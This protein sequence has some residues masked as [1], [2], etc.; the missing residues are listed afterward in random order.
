MT[1]RSD[2]IYFE[3]LGVITHEFT[4]VGYG[5]D[6]PAPPMTAERLLV[7]MKYRQKVYGKPL[8]DGFV[9]PPGIDVAELLKQLP[10][11]PQR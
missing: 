8:P 3:S 6:N 7:I 11:S 5:P 1:D 4:G 2:D 10:P 9:P